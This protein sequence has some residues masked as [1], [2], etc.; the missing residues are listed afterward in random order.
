M[1]QGTSAA[2][3][4]FR[5]RSAKHALRNPV[6]S[7]GVHPVHDIWPS[8]PPYLDHQPQNLSQDAI[9][10]QYGWL[11][12]FEDSS[13]RPSAGVD[14]AVFGYTFNGNSESHDRL[15]APEIDSWYFSNDRPLS[16]DVENVQNYQTAS[17]GPGIS[18]WYTT[19]PTTYMDVPSNSSYSVN[20]MVFENPHNF[21]SVPVTNPHNPHLAPP[22]SS[23]TPPLSK[24]PFSTLSSAW[25]E[26]TLNTHF[27]N[28]DTRPIPTNIDPLIPSVGSKFDFPGG[29]SFNVYEPPSAVKV[30]TDANQRSISPPGVQR[31]ASQSS[32]PSSNESGP[33]AANGL[34]RKRQSTPGDEIVLASAGKTSFSDCVTVF[35]TVPGAISQTKRRRKLSPSSHESFKVTRKIGACLECRFRKRPVS[36]QSLQR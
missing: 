11:E 27:T 14:K 7:E 18:G 3:L 12:S 4:A 9:Y 23:E 17:F 10:T 1:S 32:E 13:S 29:G 36:I 25:S 5:N 8:L 6:T 21:A 20:D 30:E 24:S 16:H 15:P 31:P 28:V 34:I 2:A 26:D 35:E 22:L 19:A 33:K